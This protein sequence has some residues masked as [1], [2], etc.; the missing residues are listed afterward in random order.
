MEMRERRVLVCDCESTMPLDEGRLG[1][2][3]Q[4]AGAKGAPGLNSQLCRAQL[5]NFQQV[6]LSG[7][8]VLVACTQEAPLFT[9]IAAEDKPDADLAFVNIRETA[10][11]AEQADG[12]D[13]TAK[14]AALLAESALALPPS[15]TV[16]FAS[17]G[18]C[19]VYGRDE[20]AIEA[21]KQLSGRLE[22]TVLLKEPGEVIPPR[23]MDVPIFKG[24][25]VQAKGHLGAFG[26]TVNGY[27]PAQPS[28]R[29]AFVF[30][31]PRDNAFSECDL[32]L[33]LTGDTPLFP[34]H[35][36]RDGYLRPDPDNPALVQKALFELADLVGEF[37][38]PRYVNYDAAICAHG[39]SRKT[40]CT[41]CL[42]VCPT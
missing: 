28:S 38:K 17:K 29:L 35:E 32:I 2:A 15:P 8:P 42:D 16:S 26:I 24:S 39:R 30:E 10:G 14:I 22:V 1:K 7:D 4:A 5:G 34:S 20:R 12:P 37:E 23:V 9:E 13:A 40:G 27:A 19:L 3:C 21:A 11:W 31:A 41:R 25:I 6:I 18:V 36:R 33:D